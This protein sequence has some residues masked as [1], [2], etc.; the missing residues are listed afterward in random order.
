MRTR[1]LYIAVMLTLLSFV[2]RAQMFDWATQGGG[3]GNA[4]G[5]ACAADAAGNV[6]TTGMFNGPGT[7]SNVSIPVNGRCYF[8]TKHDAQGN[9]LWTQTGIS[10]PGFC[11]HTAGNSLTIDQQG[12]IYVFGS[13]ATLISIGN[14]VFFTSSNCEV[15]MF[16]SKYDANGNVLWAKQLPGTGSQN[17]ANSICADNAGHIYITGSTASDS[18]DLGNGQILYSNIPVTPNKS[19]LAKLDTAGVCL[20][21]RGGLGGAG[22]SADAMGNIWATGS[23]M[24]TIAQGSQVANASTANDYDIYVAKYDSNGNV[25]F[26]KSAGGAHSDAGKDIVTD[27]AGNAYVT[28]H[29]LFSASFGSNNVNANGM[30]DAFIAKY[31]ANGN[32]S[33]VRTAGGSEQD[34]GKAIALD[35]SGRLFISG[36]FNDAMV[37]GNTIAASNS[38]PDLFVAKMDTTGNFHWAK[39]AGGPGI[40]EAYGLAA[41]INN[42]IFISGGFEST[43]E[44]GADN[45]TSTGGTFNMF[46]SRITFENIPV[47]N[48]INEMHDDAISIYPNPASDVVHI[49]LSGEHENASIEII[50]MCGK[51]VMQDKTTN[52]NT[53]IDVRGLSAGVYFAQIRSRNRNIVRTLLI[54]R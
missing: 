36:T 25:L 26:L 48:G 41:G 30:Y 13:F 21:V 54:S 18:L 29:F 8:I 32:V 39:S 52:E 22:I 46:L 49:K 11:T 42:D 44:F 17:F 53:M 47:P 33:W 23:F 1:C 28:G 34:Y 3:E 24:G 4:F 12:N 5:L 9:L 31:D 40:E 7:F 27:A 35:A 6:Y 14:N 16:I 43:A 50:D 37:F 45:I 51:V 2:S 10:P 15:D 20:W 19:F 38:A